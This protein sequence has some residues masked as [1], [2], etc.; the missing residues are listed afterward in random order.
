M[1]I[2][3][4]GIWLNANNII[5]L[6][7]DTR[8]FSNERICN[9]RFVKSDWYLAKTVNAPCADVAAVINKA[10]LEQEARGE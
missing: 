9:I 4:F 7:E 3:V 2:F 1:L 5:W 10:V 6:E 8:P